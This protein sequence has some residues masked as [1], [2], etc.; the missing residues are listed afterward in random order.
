MD[1]G[2]RRRSETG[3]EKGR[4]KGEEMR[5]VVQC[6][7]KRPGSGGSLEEGRSRRDGQVRREE[8]RGGGETRRAG[9]P[10]RDTR[11]VPRRKIYVKKLHPEGQSISKTVRVN[12][13]THILSRSVVQSHSAKSVTTRHSTKPRYRPIAR[14]DSKQ[15]PIR[16]QDTDHV[17]DLRPRVQVRRTVK[18]NEISLDES[19]SQ[20]G[21]KRKRTT[22]EHTPR[23]LTEQ[24]AYSHSLVEL[25][26]N[27][28]FIKLSQAIR[29]N[30]RRLLLTENLCN[31][32]WSAS[33]VEEQLRRESEFDHRAYAHIRKSSGRK[34]HSA[35]I[36]KRS[37]DQIKD[38]SELETSDSESESSDSGESDLQSASELEGCSTFD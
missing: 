34:S 15:G 11:T 16:S 37:N 9:T 31:I 32:K 35:Q 33:K 7:G 30:H 17:T 26:D 12:E 5:T 36:R 29:E 23:W 1:D 10:P 4:R 18:L 24:L 14:Q 25:L 20:A 27:N 8:R 22:D 21:K 2:G 19:S 13:L 3:R 28:N 38:S 6:E